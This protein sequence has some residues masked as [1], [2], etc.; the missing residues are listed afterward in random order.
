MDCLRHVPR[1]EIRWGNKPES[2]PSRWLVQEECPSRGLREI[3]ERGK[4][5]KGKW[6]GKIKRNGANSP[7]TLPPPKSPPFSSILLPYL[8]CTSPLVPMMVWW[9]GM[10]PMCPFSDFKKMNH[11]P[12]GFWKKFLQKMDLPLPWFCSSFWK[13]KICLAHINEHSS[14]TIHREWHSQTCSKPNFHSGNMPK[15]VHDNW[16]TWL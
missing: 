15:A 6:L 12:A 13:V 7:L 8:P 10:T 9:W 3:L 2:A 14:C 11:V 16:A 1:M 5:K 4:P